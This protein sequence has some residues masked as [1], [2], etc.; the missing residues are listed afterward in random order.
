MLLS[1]HFLSLPQEEATKNCFRNPFSLSQTYTH[2]IV[3][4]LWI[5]SPLQF[6]IAIIILLVLSSPNITLRNDNNKLKMI[7]E[8]KKGFRH[9]CWSKWGDKEKARDDGEVELAIEYTENC[10]ILGRISDWYSKSVFN[11]FSLF[12]HSH[13]QTTKFYLFTHI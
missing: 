10:S 5:H 9:G 6:M 13:P 4:I 7:N 11:D 2:L 3:E 12:I 8:L 1:W